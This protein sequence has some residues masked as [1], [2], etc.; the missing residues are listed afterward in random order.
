[1]IEVGTKLYEFWNKG[2]HERIVSRVGRK[3]FYIEGD[4]REQG[5]D[6]ETLKFSH[7]DYSQCDVQ[8]YRTKQEILDS[9]ELSQLNDKI[10]GYFSGYGRI[11]LTLQQLRE[12]DKII[13]PK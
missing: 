6:K 7:K 8:L 5:Y 10:R 11:N 9:R 1:M 13:N 2:V 4:G 3:Y 12:I